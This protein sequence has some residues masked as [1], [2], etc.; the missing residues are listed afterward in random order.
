MLASPSRD[1]L[2]SAIRGTSTLVA[3]SLYPWDAGERAAPGLLPK[4][5]HCASYTRIWMND[6]KML[7]W[8]PPSKCDPALTDA[9]LRV[10][11]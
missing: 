7:F 11:G 8:G 4:A 5:P 2:P 6:M 3:E 10:P 1:S 9:S